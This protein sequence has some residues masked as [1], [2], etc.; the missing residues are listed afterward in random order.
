MLLPHTGDITRD[1]YKDASTE[2][3]EMM[4]LSLS[5]VGL[6]AKAAGLKH[7]QGS[8][9]GRVASF[10]PHRS[11]EGGGVGLGD[12]YGVGAELQRLAEHAFRP[13]CVTK[14][15]NAAGF[16]IWLLY[17][18]IQCR[19]WMTRQEQHWWL[20]TSVRVEIRGWFGYDEGCG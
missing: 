19:L 13:L 1:L 7:E 6:V 4:D 20:H 12:A 2:F 18:T 17:V 8:S 10:P 3:E 11:H 9:G 15:L 14:Y 5:K 16:R